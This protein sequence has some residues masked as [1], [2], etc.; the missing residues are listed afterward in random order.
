MTLKRLIIK[1]VVSILF[2]KRDKYLPQQPPGIMEGRRQIWS[3]SHCWSEYPEWIFWNSVIRQHS[4]QRKFELFWVARKEEN[5]TWFCIFSHLQKFLCHFFKC[6]N[7]PCLSPATPFWLCM[8][9]S[10]HQQFQLG[11]VILAQTSIGFW[12]LCTVSLK[13]RSHS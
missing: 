10:A 6:E 8:L 4:S 5:H 3:S 2:P 7:A 13:T 11:T 1:Q 12:L 9:L